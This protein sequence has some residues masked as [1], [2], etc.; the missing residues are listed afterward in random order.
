M[1]NYINANIAYNSGVTASIELPSITNVSFFGHIDPKWDVMADVQFTNWS[2]LQNLTFVRTDGN[3]LQ[4]TPENF[5]DAWR[6]SV[7]ASYYLD[8]NWK[9]RGGLAYDQSPV[10]DAVHHAAPA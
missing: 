1:T 4:S 10:Q 9:F 2:M 6:F 3:V 5:K 7:G 8:Q